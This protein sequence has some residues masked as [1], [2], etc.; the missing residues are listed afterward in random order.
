MAMVVDG[1]IV[2]RGESLGLFGKRERVGGG[3]E[4]EEDAE[5][6]MKKRE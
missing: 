4:E 5:K 1:M 6:R 2:N 3:V